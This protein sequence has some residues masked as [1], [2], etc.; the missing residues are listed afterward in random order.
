MSRL[1]LGTCSCC[2]EPVFRHRTVDNRQL[3]CADLARLD[4]QLR[5]SGAQST[6]QPDRQFQVI[7]GGRERHATISDLHGGEQ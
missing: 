1:L 5:Q 7:S 2:G 6:L 3:S 4:E